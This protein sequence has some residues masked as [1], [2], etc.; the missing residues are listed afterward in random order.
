MPILNPLYGLLYKRYKKSL[1]SRLDVVPLLAGEKMRFSE[2][3][4]LP[5]RF[6]RIHIP[7]GTELDAS[8]VSSLA[9]SEEQF[10]IWDIPQK[11]PRLVILGERGSG[12]GMTLQYLAVMLASDLI[13]PRLIT[14]WAGVWQN[15]PPSFFMPVLLNLP[16]FAAQD[17]SL[18]EYMAEVCARDRFPGAE[19]WLR[20]RWKNG[21]CFLMLDALEDVPDERRA[22]V[23]DQ[24]ARLGRED[25]QRN[26][27]IV[28]AE[29][30]G[31]RHELEGF[32]TFYLL[33]LSQD[34]I[35]RFLEQRFRSASDLAAGLKGM[36]EWTPALGQLATRPLFLTVLTTAYNANL[37]P[38]QPVWV[39]DM[40]EHSIGQLLEIGLKEASRT[41]QVSL[42]RADLYR[43]L[44]QLA[45]E[46]HHQGRT[47]M[48]KEE[49]KAFSARVLGQV[50]T[51]QGQATLEKVLHRSG[52]WLPH[53]QATVGFGHIAFQEYL[54]AKE[55]L[56]R[57]ETDTILSR[58][59]DAWWQEVIVML[60]GLMDSRE[61]IEKIIS[62]GDASDQAILVAARCLSEAELKGS[63]A[64]SLREQIFYKV[65]RFF[66]EENESRWWLAAKAIASMEHKSLQ[67]TFSSLIKHPDPSVR[68]RAALALGRI[69]REWATGILVVAL[70]DSSPQVVARAAEA[71]GHHKAEGAIAALVQKLRDL[72]PLVAEAACRAL[73]EI[74]VPAVPN[75]IFELRASGPRIRELASKALALIGEPAVPQLIEVMNASRRV[76]MEARQQAI[77]TLGA[78]GSE[79]AVKPLIEMLYDSNV[80]LNRTAAEALGQI[81]L[82][83][84]PA[85]V[86]APAIHVRALVDA[87]PWIV[88]ALRQ[89]G[90]EATPYLIR[91]LEDQRAGVHAV[92]HG[93]LVSIGAAAIPQI[94]ASLPEAPINVQRDLADILAEIGDPS[95]VTGLISYLRVPAADVRLRIARALGRIRNSQA[96][97]A[98]LERLAV[99]KDE[100]VRR[101]ILHSLGEIGDESAVSFLARELDNPAMRDAAAAALRRIGPPAVR[102]LI[103]TIYNTQDDRLRQ[104]SLRVLGDIGQAGLLREQSLAS[105]A[106]TFHYLV[107]AFGSYDTK[108]LLSRLEGISWWPP[109]QE[110]FLAFRNV[111]ELENIRRLEDAPEYVNKLAWVRE[112]DHWFR[113]P[114]REILRGLGDIAENVKLYLQE[115]RHAGHQALLSSVDKI[116]NELLV[117]VNT[118]LLDFEK[119][120]FGPVVTHWKQLLDQA[121]IP[122]RGSAR[123]E[124]EPLDQV[125]RLETPNATESVIFRLTNMGDGVARNLRVTFSPAGQNAGARVIGEA[126][127][128]LDPLGSGTLREIEFFIQPQG[129]DQATFSF[130]VR[131]DDDEGNNRVRFFS[132]RVRFNVLPI[133]EYIEI[134][135]SPYIAGLPIKTAEMFFGRQEDKEWIAQNIGGAHQQNVLVL[136]GERRVGKTSILYQLE[137]DPPTPR[138]ICILFNLELHAPRSIHK[139]LFDMATGIYRGLR[140]RD[141]AVPRPERGDYDAYPEDRFREFC[142]ELPTHIGNKVVVLMMDEFGILIEKVHDGTLPKDIL[143]F[144]RGIVQAQENL[145]FIFV[146]AHLLRNLL[147]DEQ[148]FLF[149]MAKVRKIEYLKP[150]A[151]R[152][153]IQKPVAGYLD[154]ADAVVNR[155]LE[156][157]ACHPYFIQYIC[158]DLVKLAQ[159]K[160]RNY[161]N[162]TDFVQVLQG[163]IED[164]TGNIER[165]IYHYLTDEEKRV[166]VALAELTN[167]QVIYVTI[168][169]IIE[170][171]EQHDLGMPTTDLLEALRQLRERDLVLEQK[172]GSRFAYGFKMGLVRMW[173]KEK[174]MLVRVK[175]ERS[176]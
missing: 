74:G 21:E 33:G 146:G 55:V 5:V 78:I 85:L 139:L 120:V 93:A 32:S 162:M 15:P 133:S 11:S 128:R 129:D 47:A 45:Y 137:N 9:E 43:L 49:F 7:K 41:S 51:A 76:E 131:Y 122:L 13:P 134:P 136:H 20:E 34:G 157:T 69:G 170:V 151:A 138:H 107:T 18:S 125:V 166:L 153:L 61:L 23:L 176:A 14:L 104:L 29:S 155:I 124:L 126:T 6:Q 115:R 101:Q 22:W 171:L 19:G 68:E 77:L 26:I 112:E 158:D 28:T 132:P 46:M 67:E 92:V 149:N 116:N 118:K 27:I 38:G 172:I 110:L 109:G 48:P 81:G 103:E 37:R 63:I 98:L 90:E 60:S 160:R 145:T 40:Y 70:G 168:D 173:L 75:L 88:E 87:T 65:S 164:A 140:R 106:N 42:S 2:I 165:S 58:V 83:A 53:S 167:E 80:E 1:A 3:E 84:V 91:A 105:V 24:I 25:G 111:M 113:P 82:A 30:Y 123:P 79:S 52:L 150:A 72:N 59:D 95:A 97:P 35:D 142:E 39:N 10:S 108:E 174:D 66:E 135:P 44:Q 159:A 100:T 163:T 73:A 141:I 89:V 119:G 152:Q 156:V 71:L 121:M 56:A 169:Q 102:P 127:R 16:D 114:L 148:S 161:V 130:E 12:K 147:H 17:G 99:E 94:I 117:L 175:E 62:A 36:M 50:S 31:Y 144:F 54:A 64:D 96:V 86:E 143:D 8:G 4:T 154:Y 57:G